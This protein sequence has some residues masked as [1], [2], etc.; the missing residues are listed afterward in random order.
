MIGVS[1]LPPSASINQGDHPLALPET[2][3]IALEV[4]HPGEILSP[5]QTLIEM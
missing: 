4:L 5:G 3:I 2:L 1:L